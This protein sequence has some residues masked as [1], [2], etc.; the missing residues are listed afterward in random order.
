MSREASAR[1]YQQNKE[2]IQK[3]SC[4]SLVKYQ[5]LT[6]EEKTKKQECGRK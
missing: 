3:K 5:N 1:Y 6:D 4:E 2:K